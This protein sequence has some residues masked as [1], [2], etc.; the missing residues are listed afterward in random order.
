MQQLAG[1]YD[2]KH[3][4]H[5]K[6]F[7]M[8]NSWSWT[9]WNSP[10]FPFTWWQ[11]VINSPSYRVHL[12]PLF[13]GCLLPIIILYSSISALRHVFT[14]TDF[15]SIAHINHRMTWRWQLQSARERDSSKKEFPSGHISTDSVNCLLGCA[16]SLQQHWRRQLWGNVCLCLSSR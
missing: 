8:A 9:L 3:N 2:F 7:L 10:F 5:S 14:I 6:F 12:I 16:G 4:L 15:F 13:S 11:C 1:F